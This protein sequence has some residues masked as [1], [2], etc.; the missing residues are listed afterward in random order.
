M[1][2][3]DIPAGERDRT[4]VFALD[5]VEGQTLPLPP[6]DIERALGAESLDHAHVEQ[7]AAAD[8]TGVG[9]SGYLTEGLGLPTADVA[10]LREQLGRLDHALLVHSR[11]FGGLAHS[12]IVT[13]P[14]RHLASLSQPDTPITLKPL[15]SDSA[16]G[17]LGGPEG[18]AP[19]PRRSS[20]RR[21]ALVLL[22][23]TLLI[24]LLLQAF[25][26]I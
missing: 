15:Q 4:H 17:V 18:P 26:I 6:Q 2:V 9:L 5:L 22:V 24:F 7:I 8:L 13:P 10:P 23:A 21:F 14:L 11:A 12:L 25:R 20:A 16:R 19:E 1:S 3:L